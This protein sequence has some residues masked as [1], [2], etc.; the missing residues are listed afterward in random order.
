MSATTYFGDVVTTG[1]TNIVQKLTSYGA[2]SYFPDVLGTQSI[3]SPV[4][5]FGN[6]FANSANSLSM[7]TSTFQVPTLLTGNVYA[8]NAYQGGDLFTSDMN[9]TGISN[10]FSM[11]VN[12]PNV[13][14]GTSVPIILGPGAQAYTSLT[15]GPPIYAFG[16][17]SAISADGSTI[18]SSNSPYAL[19]Y[20]YN[21][22]SWGSYQLI[23]T[24]S[25][26]SGIAYSVALSADG[27]TALIGDYYANGQ[28]GYAA[29]F[30]YSGGSWINEQQLVSSAPGG[31]PYVRFGW[32]VALSADGNTAL[33]GAPQATGSDDGWAG[34][35]RYSGGVWG[36]ATSLVSTAGYGA[37]FGWCVALSSDGN[38]AVVGAFGT[39]IG[40]YRYTGGVWS[41]AQVISVSISGALPQVTG[42]SIT[43]DGNTVVAGFPN[44]YGYPYYSS[45]TG[46]VGVYNYSGG[47]WG[48]TIIY[49]SAGA[50]ARFGQSVSIS[51]D[52]NTIAVGAI[53]A[54]PNS[55]GW[56][57]IYTNS[58]GSWGSPTQLVYSTPV[59]PANTWFGISIGVATG[60]TRIFVGTQ[61]GAGVPFIVQPATYVNT[62]LSVQ[63]NVYASNLSTTNV[64]SNVLNVYSTMNVQSIFTSELD[65]VVQPQPYP[66]ISTLSATG[67]TTFGNVVAISSDGTTMVTCGSG[68]FPYGTSAFS[69]TFSN[70][71]W[72]GPSY[73]PVSIDASLSFGY[74]VSLSSNGDVAV[75][76]DPALAPTLGTP[77]GAV[78]FYRRIAGVWNLE[79][80]I[81][82]PYLPAPPYLNPKFGWSVALSGDG[83]T[84]VIGVPNAYPKGVLNI[85]TW[86]GSSWIT[87]EINPPPY[88]SA[89]QNFGWSVGISE[90]GNTI[91]ATT[92]GNSPGY[93]IF[94]AA[95]AVLGGGSG[96]PGPKP[97]AMTSDGSFVIGG[98]PGYEYLVVYKRISET[99]WDFYGS[100]SSPYPPGTD[101]GAAVA[102]SSDLTKL[103]VGAPKQSPS[104]QGTVFRF[105]YSVGVGWISPQELVY[106]FSAP[107]DNYFGKSISVSGDGNLAV[108]GTEASNALSYQ[109]LTWPYFSP[110]AN[111]NITGTAWVSNSI[112]TQN[113]F[114]TTLNTATLNTSTLSTTQVVDVGQG[115]SASTFEVQ[116]N[117]YASNALATTN[118]FAN[119]YSVNTSLETMNTVNLTVTGTA[120][121]SST[122]NVNSINVSSIYFATASPSFGLIDTETCPASPGR[123]LMGYCVSISSDG[124]TAVIGA[125]YTAVG[126]GWAGVYRRS[127][128]SWSLDAA[129]TPPGGTSFGS[130]GKAVA[131]SADGNT[132]IVGDES[133]TSFN[134]WAGVYR[135][136]GG[137]WSGPTSLVSG[138]GTGSW[139]GCAVALSADGNKAVVGAK[140]SSSGDGWVGIYSYSGSWSSASA[141]P[142][143]A[144]PSANFGASVS[145]ASDGNTVL[146][147]GPLNEWAGIYRYS[148]SWTE[149][150]LVSSAGGG[151]QFG[152]AVSLSADGNTAIVG[153]YASSYG[154]WAAVYRYSGGSWNEE[155]VSGL[156]GAQFG[157][158][159]CISP[160]GNTA[161]VG[162]PTADTNTGYAAIYQYSSGA[163]NLTYS[164]TGTSV[165][166]N[167]G[168]SV[169][170]SI[171]GLNAIVGAFGSQ[172]LFG[173]TPT[174]YFYG[175]LP[176][177]TSSILTTVQGNVFASNTLSGGN[178]S[179]TNTIYYNEDLTKR[180]LYL[181]PSSANATAIQSV[182]SATCNASHG[183]Y[184]CTSPAPV[185]A[186]VVGGSSSSN[187]YSGGVL[188]P[189]GRVVFVTSNCSNV[190]IY[191]P[192][193]FSLKRI[194]G[195][196]PGFNGGVLLPNGNVLFIP[197]VS[198]VAEFNPVTSEFSNVAF[199]PQGAF[200]GVLGP[201]GVYLTPQKYNS[202][203][204]T[205]IYLYSYETRSSVPSLP[206][207]QIASQPTAA[208]AN[209]TSVSGSSIAWCSGL[210]M[211]V[212]IYING[213]SF[214]SYDGK[215]WT[216]NSGPNTLQVVNFGSGLWHCV[217]A[218]SSMFVAVGGGGLVNSAYSID[219]INWYGLISGNLAGL[220]LYCTWLAVAWNPVQSKFM[221]VGNANGIPGVN[222]AESTDGMNWSSSGVSYLNEGYSWNSL[223]F[224]QYGV[225]YAIATGSGVGPLAAQQYGGAWLQWPAAGVPLTSIGTVWH[226]LAYSSTLHLF[227]AVGFEAAWIY[228]QGYGLQNWVISSPSLSS[229]DPACEWYSVSWSPEK[230]MFIA[231]G[232]GYGGSVARSA[233]SQNGQAWYPLKTSLYSVSPST[234]WFSVTWS[235]SLQIWG[236]IGDSGYTNAAYI[237]IKDL[238]NKGSILLPS[239][240][241]LFSPVGSS[242]IMEYKYQPFGPPLYSN[243]IIGSDIFS[244]LVLA[245]NGNVITVPS[246]SNIY[247][248]N[249]TTRI[250][251]NVGPITGPDVSN[252]FNGG[253]LL[254]S[255]NIVFAPGTSGNV[256]MFDPIALTYSNSVSTG[257]SGLAFS[258]ATLIPSGQVVFTPSES[259]NVGVFDT[260]VAVSP[261]FCLSPYFN[262]F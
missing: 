184:W 119:I 205:P 127:G 141:L 38:T 96:I 180:S 59:F 70:G 78:Y 233:Y 171:N 16:Y 142:N 151:A 235:P 244:G 228:E 93:L 49:S 101:F 181:T 71:T 104:N 30:K 218:N 245:P 99:G 195:A 65:S 239:G 173:P 24:S 241:V 126:P 123:Y 76:G 28:L 113:L 14:I 254:P 32:S 51:S 135:Y 220:N 198:N 62:S 102:I 44:Y 97:V 54:A 182:I 69:Y 189:D 175:G 150:D 55:Q 192:S 20:K 45:E 2:A 75:I 158:S 29:T 117:V 21:G 234:N 42:L 177:S 203:F 251:T 67:F 89:F 13:G 260:G 4:T 229:V 211:F 46:I 261:E 242:N 249:P 124:S 11:I 37:A 138:A 165:N 82:S 19:V 204:N 7:N 170:I 116:G 122:I 230:G 155:S 201:E 17:Y 190:S 48:E 115:I 26:T 33:I 164:Y 81:P 12:A 95:G 219:G 152:S 197:Q 153:A 106:P 145:M 107:V 105:T 40:V 34:I 240:N 79:Q 248:I 72:S 237:Y 61:T 247:V 74:S 206:P 256:G 186:N 8:S 22:S 53:R 121:V 50:N 162:A 27:T 23:V 64:L 250:S 156:S 1:N 225:P 92:T 56:A 60:G 125:P 221:A 3:G 91:I 209:P 159:V 185:Y 169:A 193:D 215:N 131:I 88:V 157:Y 9:V 41:S 86:N 43:G 139:F 167:F 36:S 73:L 68:T 103:L 259:A 146:V 253:A 83:N 160:D 149:T 252:F 85:A 10:T 100:V 207:G 232:L 111:V 179:V 243:I 57:A 136:S 212:S 18:I 202:L 128:L 39:Y 178:L 108:I 129:L 217:A 174:A 199:I 6:V 262:K 208:V 147:G 130:F 183:S 176:S 35:Y 172:F 168:F 255:G 118:I 213:D 187:A 214:Y 223:S 166:A 148:G 246:G 140:S 58:G 47:S 133:N 216:F 132:V 120:N 5:P 224:D 77:Y 80:T 137:S 144:G 15:P 188:V 94:N 191:N 87:Y 163:W 134:G 114:T 98:S 31:G 200:N 143:Y 52:G 226:S 161:I 257:T 84:A 231:V 227:V 194:T 25:G 90:D 236:T 110:S 109:W 238:V 112:L 63:G 66:T 258:G 210:A 196:P 222:F 154:G